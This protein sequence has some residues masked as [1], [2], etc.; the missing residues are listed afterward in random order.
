MTL[1]FSRRRP[2]TSR[3][4]FRF[5][6]GRTHVL[7]T[8]G[9]L[10]VRNFVKHISSHGWVITTSGLGK[11]TATILK[12]YF[13][14]RLWPT[15]RHRHL[16]SIHHTIFP[17][18]RT[19]WG[20]AMTLCHFSRWR[21]LAILHGMS[22]FTKFWTDR[23][24]DFGILQFVNFGNLALKMPIDAPFGGFLGH[25]PQVMSLFVLT[26]KRTV[27]GLN[28]VVWAI[29]REY[30]PRGLS[31]VLEREKRTVYRTGQHRK[32][33]E[34]SRQGYFS[35]ICGEAPTEAIYI[36]NYSVCDVLDVITCAKFQNEIFRGYDFTGGRIY[37]F[38]TDVWMGLWWLGFPT[39]FQIPSIYF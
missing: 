31:W 10:S 3:I 39:H 15:S 5:Q 24:Y 4:N 21:T 9:S 23:M 8:L 25:I 2:L 12:F 20:L 27:P 6:F 1:K 17:M 18:N 35:P 14:F 19:V 36:K 7:R 33:Q 38:P 29:N 16:I 11:R 30:W 26:S 28:Y 13:W 34:K 37:H 32:G 22:F